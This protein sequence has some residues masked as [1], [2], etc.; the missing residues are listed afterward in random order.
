MGL[1]IISNENNTNLTPVE[2]IQFMSGE[3]SAM[4]DEHIHGVIYMT[5]NLYHPVGQNGVMR[6]LWLPGYRRAGT[7][8]TDFVDELGAAW[9]RFVE[10]MD[11]DLVPSVRLHETPLGDFDVRPSRRALRKKKLSVRTQ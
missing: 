10:A 5:P 9:Y 11:G 7:R 1:V 6:S 8:L 4:S 2:L 3:L